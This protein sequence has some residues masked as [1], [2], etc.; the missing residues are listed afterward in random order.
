MLFKCE[1]VSATSNLGLELWARAW[2][3]V[4]WEWVCKFDVGPKTL[5]L[6]L[7]PFQ[8]YPHLSFSLADCLAPSMF[9]IRFYIFRKTFKSSSVRTFSTLFDFSTTFANKGFCLTIVTIL[10]FGLR[11]EKFTNDKV[12]FKLSLSCR[13]RWQPI[14]HFLQPSKK[15][16]SC[17]ALTLTSVLS[18]R[19]LKIIKVKFI[20]VLIY[21]FA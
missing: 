6:S 9:A 4:L 12:S 20:G 14:V 10:F 16:I 3:F 1:P 11:A 2:D 15:R 17:K 18:L 13:W 21:N 8:L 5:S 7:S 19:S